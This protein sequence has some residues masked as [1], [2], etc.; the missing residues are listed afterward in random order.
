MHVTIDS[1][2]L[3][4]WCERLG[5]LMDKRDKKGEL[6]ALYQE[7]AAALL[8]VSTPGYK[9]AEKRNT[10]RPGLPCNKTWKL[11]AEKIEAEYQAFEPAQSDTP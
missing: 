8:G 1:F 4:A 10:T 3:I 9:A 5:A 11:L 2:D 6:R 7:E